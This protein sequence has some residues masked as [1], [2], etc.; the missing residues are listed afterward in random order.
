MRLFKV[1]GS[2]H[3]TRNPRITIHITQKTAGNTATQ[4]FLLKQNGRSFSLNYYYFRQFSFSI[5]GDICIRFNLTRG[6]QICINI[7]KPKYVC[8]DAVCQ[9]LLRVKSVVR[10]SNADTH[11]DRETEWAQVLR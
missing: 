3:C 4:A 6:F 5:D 2:A 10:G 11:R 9:K 8:D 1:I 7:N